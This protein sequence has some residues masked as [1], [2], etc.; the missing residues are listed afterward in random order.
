MGKSNAIVGINNCGSENND[1]LIKLVIG[2]IKLD[3]NA[4]VTFYFKN[5][6]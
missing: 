2:Y 5:D 1:S 6:T 3:C 4:K